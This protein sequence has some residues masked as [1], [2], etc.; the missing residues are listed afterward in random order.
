MRLRLSPK[1]KSCD[2]PRVMSTSHPGPMSCSLP[3]PAGTKRLAGHPHP[4]ALQRQD[5]VVPPCG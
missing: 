4:Q 3:H 1:A 2:S 5:Q